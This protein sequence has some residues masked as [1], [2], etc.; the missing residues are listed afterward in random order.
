MQDDKDDL[1]KKNTT[2]SLEDKPNSLFQTRN[3]LEDPCFS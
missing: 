3:V 2:Q 1:K